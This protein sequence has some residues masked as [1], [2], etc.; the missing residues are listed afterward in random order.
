MSYVGRCGVNLFGAKFEFKYMR[1]FKCAIMQESARIKRLMS[2]LEDGDPIKI[3][4]V[5]GNDNRVFDTLQVP[6]KIGLND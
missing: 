6:E 2:C 4:F 5:P 1:T 3:K